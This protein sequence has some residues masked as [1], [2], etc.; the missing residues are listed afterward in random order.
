[1]KWIIKQVCVLGTQRSTNFQNC[2]CF[3]N[4]KQP[5]ISGFFVLHERN[6]PQMS[7]IL[8]FRHQPGDPQSCSVLYF[9][10]RNIPQI[11]S[12]SVLHEDPQTCR[13]QLWN[14]SCTIGRFATRQFPK[15]PTDAGVQLMWGRLLCNPPR[16]ILQN[17]SVYLV[18]KNVITHF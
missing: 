12:I 6:N 14:P 2:L 8:V 7:S 17:L 1:M 9:G 18:T 3:A 10:N 13:V 16:L 4:H 5:R 15:I 11:S